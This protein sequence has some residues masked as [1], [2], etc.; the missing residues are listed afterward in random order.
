[1]LPKAPQLRSFTLAPDVGMAP[2]KETPEARSQRL[3]RAGAD[4]AVKADLQLC[5]AAM[6]ANS[7]AV[8][9][10][11]KMLVDMGFIDS[12]GSIVKGALPHERVSGAA[13]SPPD[14]AQPLA[15]TPS[16]KGQGPTFDLAS[17]FPE[18]W[19]TLGQTSGEFLQWCLR[20]AEPVAFSGHAM[21][22]L[23]KPSQRKVP[24]ALLLE[25]V[26]F[27]FDLDEDTPLT[28]VGSYGAILADMQQRNAQNG[29]RGRDLIMPFAWADAGVYRVA[30]EGNKIILT[31]KCTGKTAEVVDPGF[32]SGGPLTSIS[33]L[34][35]KN[36]STRKASLTR[37][38]RMQSIPCAQVL[39]LT[40]ATSMLEPRAKETL[41]LADG[42]LALGGPAAA[43][44][45]EEQQQQERKQELEQQLEVKDG[46]DTG[47]AEEPAA[48]KIKA[49]NA[50]ADGLP[51]AVTPKGKAPPMS[52]LT[53]ELEAS[54]SP[55]VQESA[56]LA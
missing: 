21:K 41:A 17:E 43:A 9:H 29:R 44:S 45:Q 7:A 28:G 37:C 56:T 54:F 50:G 39:P 22:A 20:E 52:A 23:L 25:M 24:K 38:G 42:V 27:V 49:T 6:K 31:N 12:A 55:Q 35:T 1:M 48:K 51:L 4:L 13:A 2:R 5:I 10:V 18:D 47:I 3:L 53:P 46:M 11:K 19:Q 26:E 16:G 33:F 30:V 36:H 34:I 8:R 14:P 15:L 40:Q 32:A